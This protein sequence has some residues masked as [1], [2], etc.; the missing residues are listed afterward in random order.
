VLALLAQ[1]GAREFVVEPN[2]VLLIF[3]IVSVLLLL[4]LAALMAWSHLRVGRRGV[5]H[6]RDRPRRGDEQR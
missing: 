3:M 5:E 4:A 1:S 6:T 2:P